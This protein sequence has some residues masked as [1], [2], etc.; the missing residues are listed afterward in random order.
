VIHTIA[1]TVLSQHQ[2]NFQ[3]QLTKSFK[4][5]KKEEEIAVNLDLTIVTKILKVLTYLN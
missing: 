5:Y 2:T 3:Y 4:C 1:I